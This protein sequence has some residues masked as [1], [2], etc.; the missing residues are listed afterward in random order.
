ME[1]ALAGLTIVISLLLAAG[2]E[3]PAPRRAGEPVSPRKG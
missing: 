2:L 3:R 1:F